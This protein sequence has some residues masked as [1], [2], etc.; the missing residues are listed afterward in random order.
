MSTN[1]YKQNGELTANTSSAEKQVKT[2]ETVQ[3]AKNTLVAQQ[4]QNPSATAAKG[5]AATCRMV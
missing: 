3:D 5:Q 2:L 1:A 4:N